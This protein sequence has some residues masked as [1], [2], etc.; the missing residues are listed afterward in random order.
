MIEDRS[1]SFW[2][3]EGGEQGV[4]NAS[5]LDH[6]LTAFS[7]SRQCSGAAIRAAMD[8]AVEQA[9][10]KSPVISGFHSPLEQSVLEVML[11]AGEGGSC[12]YGELATAPD[13]RACRAPQ[14]LGRRTCRPDCRRP[15]IPRREPDVSG[16]AVAT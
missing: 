11:T 4:G 8:W 6:P 14:R 16:N 10:S 15:C 9:R 1:L 13:R 5:L 7:A 2:S 3:L 12:Q